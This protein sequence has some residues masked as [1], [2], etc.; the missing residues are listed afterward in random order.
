MDLEKREYLEIFLEEFY[1]D[2][3]YDYEDRVINSLLHDR[4]AEELDA[5]LEDK[6]GDV[7]KLI[8]YAYGLKNMYMMFT[9]C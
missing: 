5:I 2:V 3:L 1:A 9:L 4:I 6:D 7:D 8:E